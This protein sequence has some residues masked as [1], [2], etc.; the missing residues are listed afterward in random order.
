[1]PKPLIAPSLLSADFSDLRNEMN[2]VTAA[3]ADWLHV[4]VMDGHFVPNIT[5]GMP[6]VKSL[7]LEAIFAISG[8]LLLSRSPPQPKTQMMRLS[9]AIV[10]RT[11]R[12]AFK[13]FSSAS[14]VCA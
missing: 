9:S 14:G 6:I 8:L 2:K 10:S 5:L 4:D 3:G 1:M 11:L 13:T 12:I 7:K